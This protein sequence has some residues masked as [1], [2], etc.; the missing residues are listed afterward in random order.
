M[1]E[2]EKMKILSASGALMKLGL[3]VVIGIAGVIVMVAGDGRSIAQNATEAEQGFT[4]SKDL[5]EIVVDNSGYKKDRRGPVK[6]SH[7]KHA[8]DYGVSCWE[9]HHEYKVDKDN[10]W[11]PLGNTQAC[12]ECHDPLKVQ[13]K[14]M[15]LQT[16]YHQNC[17]GCHKELAIEHKKTGAYR[18]C[19]ECHE[20]VE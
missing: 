20:K 2:E 3:M 17:K 1:I 12:I 10:I 9:C 5:N 4:I 7:T 14:A 18:K 8:L 6:L 19:L 11:S 13:D 16:A 15:R